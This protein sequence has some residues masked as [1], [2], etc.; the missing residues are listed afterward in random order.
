M[1]RVGRIW[2][3]VSVVVLMVLGLGTTV[4]AAR[5][6]NT[7]DGAEAA[8]KRFFGYINDREWGTYY[9][10]LHP[11]QQAVVSKDAF[12]ACYKEAVPN[13]LSVNNVDVTV[14]TRST[15]I[16]PGTDTAAK[17]NEL[18]V[19][20]TLERGDAEQGVT[21]RSVLIWVKNKWTWVMSAGRLAACA[22]G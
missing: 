4:A 17:V 12:T 21:D 16:I 22:G 14:A 8:A 1:R 18:T 7:A 15:V 13:G 5:D 2:V 6:Q 9:R 11:A 19:K 3:S 10:F 20:Y